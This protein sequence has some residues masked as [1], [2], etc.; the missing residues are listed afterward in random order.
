MR[1][2]NDNESE[3]VRKKAHRSG[4]VIHSEDLTV[5]YKLLFPRITL[6]IVHDSALGV[7]YYG[8]TMRSKHDKDKQLVGWN[9]AF[10]RAV[11]DIISEAQ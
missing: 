6:C 9:I 2:L 7:N 10:S 8:A 1:I 11:D 3:I 5:G 4:T